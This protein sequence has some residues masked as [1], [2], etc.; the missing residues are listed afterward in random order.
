CDPAQMVTLSPFTSATAHEGPI[1]PWSWNGQRYVDSKVL[2]A[3]E[4]ALSGLPLLA[5]DRSR[6][7]LVFFKYASSSSRLAGNF[8]PGVVQTTFRAFAA[9]IAL[10][11]FCA[12]TPTKFPCCTTFTTPGMCATELSS[13]F[14]GFE[15]TTAGR[16]T[17]PCSIS[18]IR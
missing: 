9:R 18:G 16:T 14:C 3:C 15:F 13:T 12:T 6:K 1:I 7:L 11:S 8:V 17:R 5:T 10:H 2:L 4:N